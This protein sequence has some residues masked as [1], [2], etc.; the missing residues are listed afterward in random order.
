M[1]NYPQLNSISGDLGQLVV[2]FNNAAAIIYDA[3]T[4]GVVTRLDTSQD[5]VSGQPVGPI[6]AVLSHPTLPLTI[7]GHEDRH[8]R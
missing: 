8:I 7:T 2:G 3:E 1:C 6:N 4:G 5:P